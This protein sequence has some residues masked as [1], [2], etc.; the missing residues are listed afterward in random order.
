MRKIKIA[1][2]SDIH[3]NNIALDAVIEDAKRNN[4]DEYI[5]AGDLITDFP[6]TNEVI[7]KVRE[8]TKYVIK[9][10]REN[11]I[12][13]YDRTKELDKWKTLQ[14]SNFV[15]FYNS[16]T[17][18]N[19]EYIKTLPETIS[20]NFEGLKV[21]VV[22]GSPYHISELTYFDNEELIEKICRDLEEDI[23][24][25]GHTHEETEFVKKN[26]KILLQD[27]VVG[28]HNNGANQSQYA[29]IEYENGKVN[30]IK[31]AVEYDKDKLK[32]IIEK[33]DILDKN[34][35]WTNLC[36]YCL[37]TGQDLR[38]QFVEEGR[39]KMLKKV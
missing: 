34:R 32:K 19:F 9:G 35:T 39:Q 25:F 29:I 38:T 2:L 5:V 10:N 23:L 21:K 27:G 3:G 8:L 15:Y 16:L 26:D 7:D 31:R 13:E 37:K 36:Y 14:Y 28:M 33:S 17:K 4:V 6:G 24:V 20:L 30:I 12:L 1:V 11:Y 22:H 18:D